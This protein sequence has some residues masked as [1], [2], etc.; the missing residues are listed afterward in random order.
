MHRGQDICQP[1]R[2]LVVHGVWLGSDGVQRLAE[3]GPVSRHQRDIQDF[4]IAEAM[5]P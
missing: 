1:S 3:E 5:T 2:Q 4:G